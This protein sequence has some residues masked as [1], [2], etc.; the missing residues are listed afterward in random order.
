MSPGCAA[1]GADDEMDLADEIHWPSVAMDHPEDLMGAALAE[2][3]AVDG[4]GGQRRMGV[5]RLAHVIETDE[6]EVAPGLQP[7]RGETV[8][9]A[10]G[11]DIVEAEGS[12][13]RLGHG[14]QPLDPGN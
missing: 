8:Q 10:E 1:A 9:H 7:P 12:T 11:D 4:D 6:G 5:A 13:R 2:R 3:L 14:E